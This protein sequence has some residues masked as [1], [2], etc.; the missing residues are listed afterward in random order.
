MT[1]TVLEVISPLDMK[2]QAEVFGDLAYIING[3][4]INVLQRWPFIED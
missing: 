2:K 1:K 3:I 4:I